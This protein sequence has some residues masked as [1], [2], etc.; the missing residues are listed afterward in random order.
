MIIDAAARGADR[1]I[2]V[3]RLASFGIGVLGAKNILWSSAVVSLFP[4]ARSLPPIRGMGFRW[5]RAG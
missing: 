2:I 3:G 1:R 4:A 5:S